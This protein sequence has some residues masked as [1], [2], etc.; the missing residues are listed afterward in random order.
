MRVFVEAFDRL[1]LKPLAE[2]V[3]E[4]NRLEKNAR[5]ELDAQ[6]QAQRKKEHAEHK[7]VRSQ[8]EPFR[9]IPLLISLP[10]SRSLFWLLRAWFNKWS[11]L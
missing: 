10:V 3:S 8:L 2:E 4:L 11:A 1:R 6:L 9:P 5:K 7:E